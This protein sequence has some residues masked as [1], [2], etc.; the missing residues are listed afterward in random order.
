MIIEFNISIEYY[1]TNVFI[2]KKKL[3]VSDG[4]LTYFFVTN[5]LNQRIINE[6]FCFYD[7]GVNFET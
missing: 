6:M 3:K 7:R 1:G 2:S 4:M 5:F